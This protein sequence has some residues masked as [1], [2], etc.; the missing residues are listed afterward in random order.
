MALSL[1]NLTSTKRTI[2]IFWKYFLIIFVLSLILINWS[3]IGWLFNYRLI[4]G[5]IEKEAV[6]EPEEEPKNELIEIPFLKKELG[7]VEE[8]P[9]EEIIKEDMIEIPKIDILAPI[10][11]F[12][13][14]DETDEVIHSFLDQGTVHF[15]RSALPGETGQTIILGHSAPPGWPMIKYDW[16]F[17]NLDNLVWGDEIYIYYGKEKF[18]YY[19]REKVFLDKGEETPGEPT[20]RN[21]LA[22]ISCWPPGQNLRRIV[23]VAEP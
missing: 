9:E 4:T 15:P 2:K 12:D 19:V 11:F 22:L 16:V 6:E 3:D 23:V 5:N 10:I 7:L 8:E 18:T 1:M 17:S 13:N 14:P 21:N 20:N